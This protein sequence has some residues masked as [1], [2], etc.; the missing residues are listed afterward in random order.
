LKQFFI[1]LKQFELVTG[2][3][4]MKTAIFSQNAHAVMSSQATQEV[5]HCLLSILEDNL[6]VLIMDMKKAYE[7]SSLLS[8]VLFKPKMFW[9][10]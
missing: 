4:S 9:N 2:D 3:F 6:K 1:V 7:R 8:H 10:S 5:F